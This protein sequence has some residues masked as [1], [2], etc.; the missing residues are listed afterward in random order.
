MNIKGKKE[1]MTLSDSE[2]EGAE[3][4]IELQMTTINSNSSSDIKP[5][6]SEYIDY[7]DNYPKKTKFELWVL[8]TCSKIKTGFNKITDNKI[9]KSLSGLIF[10]Y[11]TISYYV[12]SLRG[13]EKEQ[14]ECLT[15]LG[16]SSAFEIGS[17]IFFS[18]LNFTI[19]MTFVYFELT[20]KKF[21]YICSPTL[22]YL[23]YIY[24]TG[25]DFAH[26]GA[27]NRVFFYLFMSF[28][29]FIIGTITFIFTMLKRHFWKTSITLKIITFLIYLFIQRYLNNSCEDWNKGFKGTAIDNDVGVC[30]IYTP[31]NRC[32][33]YLTDGFFDVTALRNI[34][35]RKD[36]N[37]FDEKNLL[38]SFIP[39][40]RDQKQSKRLGF[41]RTESWPFFPDSIL[42]EY[43][44]NIFK[45]MIDMDRD[46][47][48]L[49]ENVEVYIDFEPDFPEVKINLKKN[50]T[51]ID[52]RRKF[53][54]ENKIKDEENLKEYENKQKLKES[55][56][57]TNTTSEE[58]Q[59]EESPV[60]PVEMPFKN[61]IQ[62]Y[63]DALSRN[64]FR[65][66]LKKTFAWL[67]KFYMSNHEIENNLVDDN[68]E[69]SSYQFLKYHSLDY[70]TYANMIPGYFGTHKWEQ[71]DTKYFLWD[72]KAKGYIVGQSSN[73][74]ER[75]GW[76][77][78][79]MFKDYL[80]FTNYDHEMNPFYCDPNFSDPDQPY[81]VFKG[82][83]SII[84]KCM[85]GKDS[86][87]FQIEYAKQFFTTYKD[88]RKFFRMMFS[89]AHEGSME[90]VK[91]LDD[92]IVDYLQF[93]HDEGHMKD[94]V[95][96]IM[97]D[98]G[99]S[100]PGP[101]FTLHAD[102]WFREVFLGALFYVIPKDHKMFKTF[103][104]NLRANE[105][106]MVTSFDIH[107]SLLN[108]VDVHNW[109]YTTYGQSL[110]TTPI[111]ESYRTC[112][113]YKIDA[114]YCMCEA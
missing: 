91:Y 57:G 78:E 73:V 103:H 59:E 31:T 99:T 5:S 96:F 43:N 75:E 86:G 4:D 72:Y 109:K 63:I 61:I 93:L 55:N 22:L 113:Y 87:E 51:L 46:D 92:Y 65:K 83:Y 97:T 50:Q 13:C 23:F 29:L 79:M 100:M 102:D 11:F 62:I 71:Y 108:F 33:L 76:D 52:E 8:K 18:A 17:E 40:E 74:C 68:L 69:Y 82:A 1:Y 84:R 7:H 42:S 114:G 105:N 112:D 19:L 3:T 58:N 27:Y 37:L 94:S 41:P 106:V 38:K 39:E 30:K 2:V 24:D 10:Y 16:P 85:Y 95:V 34:N 107:A 44:K 53:I 14:A 104:E 54:E 80:N 9:F 26:H 77:L 12:S 56:N 15:Q 36:R 20:Y 64:H 32:F 81:Q 21:L 49:T 60:N 48:S 89:D 28:Q 88:E 110:F 66:K 111:D 35:C 6:L 25:A 98:H 45:S 67:E 70:Y 47:K 101:A 90:V